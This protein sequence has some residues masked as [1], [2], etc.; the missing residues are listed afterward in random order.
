[1]TDNYTNLE[2]VP[3]TGDAQAIIEHVRATSAPRD[4]EKGHIYL[5][6]DKDGA[7]R[8]L[9]TEGFGKRPT[10]YVRAVDVHDTDSLIGYVKTHQQHQDGVEIWVSPGRDG[11]TPVVTAVL[12]ANAWRNHKVGLLFEQTPDWAAWLS[13]SG[14]QLTQDK[15]SEFVEDHVD[16][17]VTPSG[18]TMLE[19]A[20]SIRARSKSNFKSDKRLANGQTQ[21]EYTETIDAQAGSAGTIVI[22]D[23]ITLALQPFQG[24]KVYKVRAKFRYR[25]SGGNLSLGVKLLNPERVVQAVLEDVVDA[26]HEGL[27]EA[28]IALGRI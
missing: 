10:K 21:L 1:M 6:T 25:I 23:E 24:S 13:I 16:D 4:L 22:P 9:D 15:F 7:Q 17:I 26:L 12:D 20:Q 19:L 11:R 18:A 8:I 2:A 3:L 5:V 14:T 27:P 28:L